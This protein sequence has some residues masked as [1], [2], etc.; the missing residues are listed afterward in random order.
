M[1]IRF[2][3]GRAG[4]GKT[5][6][7]ARQLR[8]ELQRDPLGAGTAPGQG[9]G[10]L[11]WIVPEQGTFTAE[12]LLLTG[13]GAN[14][15][16]IGSFRAK[17][18]SFRRLATLIA[19][20]AGWLADTH[21][22]APAGKKILDDVARA[23]LLDEV[24]REHRSQLHAFRSVAH[25]RGF[26]EK[27]D[28]LLR[29]LRQ[30]GHTGASL[31]DLIAQSPPDRLGGDLAIRKLLDL[32]IILE[33]W[34]DK[35]ER[36][37]AWD[38]E[39]VL[40]RAALDLERPD[41]NPHAPALA[42]II[43]APEEQPQLWVDGFTTMSYLEIRLLV[44]L[45]KR[46]LHT[47]ITI[48]ADPSLAAQT[49]HPTRKPPADASPF[50]RTTRMYWRLRDELRRHS[51]PIE[52]IAPMRDPWR[53]AAPELRAVESLFDEPSPVRTAPRTETPDLF[54][55]LTPPPADSPA[56]ELWQSSDPET[57]VRAAAQTIRERALSA[58]LRYRNIALIV[59]RLDGPSG[60]GDAVRRI[61]AQHDIP[62]FIDQRRSVSHH[63][64]VE[65][66]RAAVAVRVH[67]AA[68]SPAGEDLLLF[69]K[70]GLAGASEDAV[71]ELENYVLAHGLL[72]GD[73]SAPWQ[74]ADPNDPE[75]PALLARLNTLR[76]HTHQLL[77][78]PSPTQHADP[79]A[80]LSDDGAAKVRWLWQLLRTLH[81]ED[82]LAAWVDTARRSARNED[83]MLHQQAWNGIAEILGPSGALENL[84]LNRPIS[85][86][87]FAE[88]LATALERLTL[89]L[90]P[91][92]V[93]QVVVSTVS[94]AWGGGVPE[95]KLVLLLGALEGAFPRVLDEDALLSATQRALLDGEPEPETL[96]DEILF[97]YLA[98]TRASQSLIISYPL[99]DRAGKAVVRSRYIA[100][101]ERSLER[102]HLRPVKRSFDA[103]T[104]TSIDRLSTV[105]DL[106]AATVSWVRR[107]IDR[108]TVNPADPL[109]PLYD[110]VVTTTDPKVAAARNAV[111]PS[112]R[113]RQEIRLALPLAQRFY[114]PA[115]ELRMSVS[116]LEKFAACPLQ[117]FMHYTLG[118]KPRQLLALD[119]LN[120][121]TLYHRILERF[122]AR[123]IAG[124]FLW[125]D[126][127]EHDLR[128]A[129][130][131]EVDA[132]ARELHAELQ[133]K[134]PSYD[135]QRQRTTR[136]LGIVLEA[137]RRRACQG[138]MRPIGVEVTFGKTRDPDPPPNPPPGT[139]R[140]LPVLRIPMNNGRSVAV[141]GKIDRVDATPA[142]GNAPAPNV[143]VP[144]VSVMDYKSAAKRD[145]DLAMVF[146]GL[147]LQ[148][149]V[150]GLVMRDLA[151]KQ[152]RAALYIPLGIRQK[153]VP[154]PEDAPDQ[155]SDAFYQQFQ[156]PR[157]IVDE[158]A[159]HLLDHAILP[160]EDAGDKS[161]WF[162]IGY[163]KDGGIPKNSDM[164]PHQD[165]QLLLDFARWK[166]ASLAA[167]LVSG[168]IAPSP[169]RSRGQAPCTDCQ[170]S[171]LC[172]FDPSTDPYRD[173]PHIPPKDTLQNMRTALTS[174]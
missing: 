56:V 78:P 24:L 80:V 174:P 32:A 116:Q 153:S 62:F 107:A 18:V 6:L 120:L 3:I 169:Y 8:Q 36:A 127:H 156:K 22:A 34:S 148:L 143:S 72:R 118:L 88:V 133:E 54:S 100:H 77:A 39:K 75:A 122:Y 26:I 27:L 166:V 85:W 157:G 7:C 81:A 69:L 45:A 57:E 53:L 12:R 109:I 159:A 129:L 119:A 137:D 132:A 76:Q 108:N 134:L 124:D 42:A 65:L 23:V 141:T 87:R 9:G 106:L 92:T 130:E 63:P 160:S 82:Q 125:P 123:V 71:A 136:S 49:H 59:P 67:T 16:P 95:M 154:A 162:N 73:W 14:E 142:H 43:G 38:F 13:G 19:R 83:A 131:H 167:E 17:V 97:D 44:A 21:G 74:W 113:D 61:F 94:R 140:R 2:L 115:D 149:P 1:G 4:T 55:T 47:T 158:S 60:Y 5:W 161:N 103:A 35:I 155:N 150:Y 121:G 86:P 99:A 96:S 31:R 163:K 84:L 51:L 172:P 145:L 110:W 173:L 93:D 147:S 165:F 41:P 139:L 28:S 126:C 20:D 89:G 138:D 58:A 170:F 30:A 15:R 114:P 64:L 29:E 52:G 37:D 111:W 10:P 164:L 112:V 50:A 25:R 48:L 135:K 79:D 152:P 104:R 66:L 33:G 144:D 98:L 128:R 90:I 91:A 46:A 101:I 70:T 146:W 105:D 40:H 151:H 168:K 102:H 117:Y 68:A 171:S 11:W